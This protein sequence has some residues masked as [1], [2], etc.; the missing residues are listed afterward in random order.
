M[1]H[2][3]EFIPQTSRIP[4]D[5]ALSSTSPRR[6]RPT[7]GA[8]HTAALLACVVASAAPL[9][10]Q[11]ISA[12]SLQGAVMDSLGVPLYEADVTI[13][14]RATGVART[15][16]TARGG[17]FEF[18]V[19]ATG[20][21]DLYV[22]RLGFRPR[23]VEAVPVR[24]GLARVVEVRL[25][26]AAPPVAQ[27]DTVGFAGDPLRG[28]GGTRWLAGRDIA[29]LTDDR[30]L[31]TNVAGLF[32]A[33]TPSLQAEGQPARLGG[34]LVDALPFVPAR[35][36]RSADGALDALVFPLAAF[37]QA[38]LLSGGG[39][40][41]ERAASGGGVLDGFTLRG[42]RRLEVHAA[43]DVGSGSRRG[44]LVI[45]GPLVRDTASFALGVSVRRLTA[46]LP[47]PWTD[48]SLANAV[49]AVARDSFG[50]D[51]GAYL[52]PFDVTT[53]IVSGF[54]RVDWQL[55]SAHTLSVRGSVTTG[56]VDNPLF[57]TLPTALGASLETRDVSA[58]GA[59]TSV[60]SRRVYQELR[61]GVQS[62]TRDWRATSL[63]GTAVADGGLAFGSGGALPG[64]FARTALRVSETVHV[65]LG[66]H[67]LKL[68][69]QLG[70]ASHDETYAPDRDG[71]FWFA[72]ADELGARRGAFVQS[73]GS[74]P[75]ATFKVSELDVFVQDRWSPAP[76]LELQVGLRIETWRLP[77]SDVQLNDEWQRRTG[78]ANTAV[79]RRR[80]RVSPRAAV[81]WT[82]GPRGEWLVLADAGVHSG[83]VNPADLGE[84][85]TNAGASRVRRGFGAIG[86]W[87]D[88]P[89][90]TAAPVVGPALTLLAP[91]YQPPRI[92]RLALSITRFFGAGALQVAG[93]YRHTDFLLRRRDLN[94]PL[95]AS[96]QDEFGRPVSG[97]LVQDGSLLAVQAGTNRR[98]TSFDQVSVL[99]PTGYADYYGA[100]LA[101]ERSV[102]SGLSLL[103]SYSYSR[104]TDNWLGGRGGAPD[105][106]LSPFPDS[107]D[108]ADW[109]EGPS[110]F[111]VP[112]RAVAGVELRL[113]GRVGARVAVLYRYRSGYPFT[114]GFRDGVDANGDGS[115]RNDPAFVTDTLPGMSDLVAGHDCLR[116][117]LDR[118]AKRN[119]CR[120]PAVQN[121]DVRF[122]MALFRVRGQ[123]A[124]LV[125]DG[126]NLLESEEGIVDRALYLVD[127]SATLA[128][129]AAAGVVAVPLVANPRFGTLLSSR[130]PKQLWRVGLRVGF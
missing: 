67:L 102:T 53:D 69:A 7:H 117:Q 34:L 87:P 110:D 43:A 91:Q 3:V 90:S 92:G 47:A 73:V 2:A 56:S 78:L 41:A 37:S 96:F 61:L 124:E 81:R 62:S 82:A 127:R 109:T 48:D 4:G 64:R 28:A 9:R 14:D 16:R 55:G 86:A 85:L 119:S 108:G 46:S 32:A 100:T 25:A 57:P 125:V 49:L 118:F 89:D 10:A 22:E 24:P 99:E 115:A 111:D 106:Q 59:L 70:V 31:L 23:L 1:P 52:R 65:G 29:D 6:T 121:L 84:L 122:A 44:T 8:A 123:S 35:H 15:A 17:G 116:T 27:V 128:T 80:D 33:G 72:G 66:A 54:A 101:L 77:A 26:A 103:A 93:T 112:H 45:S 21:Y 60:F 19:L 74:L 130:A 38:A 5:R 30:A 94:R 105:A 11:S 20:D 75:L 50:V 98:F 42:A 88:A 63:V 13:T 76:S 71:G 97:A 18:P 39:E 68:G 113:P 126:L 129:D 40:D 79:P 107:L 95:R 114:P 51:L 104:T 120:E 83:E 36:P 58:S 12:G